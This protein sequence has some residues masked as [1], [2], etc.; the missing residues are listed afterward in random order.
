MKKPV[1]MAGFLLG[2]IYCLMFIDEM[3]AVSFIWIRT[4]A[5]AGKDKYHWI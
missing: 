2:A 5:R 4:M 3:R 1:F